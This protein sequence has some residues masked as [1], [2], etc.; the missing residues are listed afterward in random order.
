MTKISALPTDSAPSGDDF[1]PTLDSTT[2]TTKKATVDSLNT[3]MAANTVNPYKFAAYMSSNQ[4]LTNASQL[5][6]VQFNTELFDTNNNYDNST[7]IYT[8]PVTGYYIIGAQLQLLSQ[9]GAVFLMGIAING[10]SETYRFGEIPNT[11][12][13]VGLSG[14]R[15]I[16]LTANDTVRVL[17]R[18][19]TAGKILNGNS[20]VSS[21]YAY[22]VSK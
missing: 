22:F 13:N 12:G 20:S 7:Y 9:A 15:L 21:F 14:S 10:T 1:L 11:T 18:S 8:I 4:T 3:Y 5:Y 19:D 2:S 6:T 17:A 16:Y